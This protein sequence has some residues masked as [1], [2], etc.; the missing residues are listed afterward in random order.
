[1]EVGRRLEAQVLDGVALEEAQRP[2]RRGTRDGQQP[3]EGLL[4]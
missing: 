3:P 1:M 4:R 2:D